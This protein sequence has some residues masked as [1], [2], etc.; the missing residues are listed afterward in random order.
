MSLAGTGVGILSQT[1]SVL[2]RYQSGA[3][4]LAE[5][6]WDRVSKLFVALFQGGTSILYGLCASRKY[7]RIGRRTAD[8]KNGNA[9]PKIHWRLWVKGSF[10]ALAGERYF[11]ADNKGHDGNI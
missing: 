4:A 9:G 11:L 2:S 8:V 3:I 6:R 10:P 5:R 7:R 1:P